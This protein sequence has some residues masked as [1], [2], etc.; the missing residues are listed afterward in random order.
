MFSYVSRLETG[1]PKR[2]SAAAH[3]LLFSHHFKFTLPKLVDIY[4]PKSMTMES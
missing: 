4:R 3:A 2:R 1:L